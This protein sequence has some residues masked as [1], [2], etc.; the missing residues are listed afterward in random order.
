[1]FVTVDSENVRSVLKCNC[2]AFGWLEVF[3]SVVVLVKVE[4]EAQ[5]S[6]T[7]IVM[8]LEHV[9]QLANHVLETGKR[10]IINISF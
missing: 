2:C 3:C 9:K 6:E 5:E 8:V 1:M 4:P 7:L 10:A